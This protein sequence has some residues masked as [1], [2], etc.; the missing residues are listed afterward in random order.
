MVTVVVHD[1]VGKHEHHISLELGCRPDRTALD[2]LLDL[3]E[4]HPPDREKSPTNHWSV[5][6]T[7]LSVFDWFKNKWIGIFMCAGTCIQ[8][9]VHLWLVC[10]TCEQWSCTRGLFHLSQ[11]EGT[12]LHIWKN[13]FTKTNNETSYKGRSTHSS[14]LIVYYRY[15]KQ[16]LYNMN[17]GFFPIDS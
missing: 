4:I 3:T 14:K 8:I 12:H 17:A 11:G 6:W 10:V 2:V 13:R 16:F 1:G 9:K 5:C 7:S 15:V